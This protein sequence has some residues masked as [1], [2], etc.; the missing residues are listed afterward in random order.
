[1]STPTPTVSEA[2]QMIRILKARAAKGDAQKIAA[3]RGIID[4]TKKAAAQL[5]LE[6]YFPD[7]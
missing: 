1:M 3:L 4:E 5:A 7:K 2:Y 6:K